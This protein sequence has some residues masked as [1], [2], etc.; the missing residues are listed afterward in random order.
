MIHAGLTKAADRAVEV[1]KGMRRGISNKRKPK[2]HIERLF[3]QC[4]KRKGTTWKHRFVC[5]AYHDQEKI[6]TTDV[7]KD[8]LFKAGLG[9]KVLEFPDMDISREV[10]NE[11]LLEEYPKLSEGGGFELCKCLPN[12]RKLERL[13]DTVQFSPGMIKERVGNARTYIRPLQRDLCLDEVL[14]LSKVQS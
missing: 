9:E 2:S 12:S 3:P 6:P 14:T 5:L 7:E 1:L 8:D 10:F 11:V 13:S 4:K